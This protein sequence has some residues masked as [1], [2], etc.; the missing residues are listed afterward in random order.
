ME[1]AGIVSSNLCRS[2]GAASPGTAEPAGPILGSGQRS[3][4][5]R[6]VR[7]VLDRHSLIVLTGP[8]GVGKTVVLREALEHLRAQGERI[9]E[10]DLPTLDRLQVRESAAQPALEALSGRVSASQ[11]GLCPYVLLADDAHRLSPGTLRLLRLLA[12]RRTAGEPAWQMILSGRP[13]LWDMVRHQEPPVPIHCPLKGLTEAEA[14]VLLARR[15][16][17]SE[18]SVPR[19]IAKDALPLLLESGQG[20]PGRLIAL[21]DTA[22][23]ISGSRPRGVITREAVAS[24]AGVPSRPGRAEPRAPH[25]WWTGSVG[26]LGGILMLTVGVAAWQFVA[27]RDE[28]RT[29]DTRAGGLAPLAREQAGRAATA[30][31][32]VA[33]AADPAGAR[34]IQASAVSAPPPG[35]SADLAAA[36]TEA[37]KLLDAE[38]EGSED[39]ATD[40]PDAD[41]SA[42]APAG[43]DADPSG[44]ETPADQAAATPRAQQAQPAPAEQPDAPAVAEADPSGPETPAEQSAA[45]PSPQQS[46]PAPAEQTAPGPAQAPAT[47][48][49]PALSAPAEP[50]GT[51]AAAQQS[52]PT[53]AEQPQAAPAQAPGAAM[54]PALF[55][56]AEPAGTGAAAQQSPPAPA[57]QPEAAP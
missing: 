47:V 50:A 23:A 20:M 35:I 9:V 26:G 49:R 51:G 12:M 13:E 1:G 28:A 19:G 46:Q 17:Q 31:V 48:I 29:Q 55:A 52:P 6:I 2:P 45:T 8:A 5:A 15:L 57:Q 4:V 18:G 42:P 25:R 40:R 38:P 10:I 36:V 56:P 30:P 33:L 39:A 43:T 32:E 53:P 22:R 27:P 44:P 54:R 14:E 34:P 11:R 24:A 7:A 41:P 21:L 37:A 16:G 3:A